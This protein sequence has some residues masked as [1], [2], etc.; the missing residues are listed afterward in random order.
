ML[1]M[2][3]A[4]LC[5]GVMAFLIKFL[6]LNSNVTPYEVAYAQG[7]IAAVL[8]ALTLYLKNVNFLDVKEEFRKFLFGRAFFGTVS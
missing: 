6:Y 7:T 2:A 8:F 3:L 5:L 1:S 4:S